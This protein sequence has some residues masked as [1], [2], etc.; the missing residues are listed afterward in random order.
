MIPANG[1]H[2]DDRML[3]DAPPNHSYDGGHDDGPGADDA[4]EGVVW[5]CEVLAHVV[6]LQRY[7]SKQRKLS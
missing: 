3:E 1:Q 2:A 7:T 4:V 6:P 5:V